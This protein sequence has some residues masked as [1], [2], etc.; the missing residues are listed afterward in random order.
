M[1]GFV[2][3]QVAYQPIIDVTAL[4]LDLMEDYEYEKKKSRQKPNGDVFQPLLVS[5]VDDLMGRYE[6]SVGAIL[7][8][9][10]E[11]SP[12]ELDGIAKYIHA[13]YPVVKVIWRSDNRGFSLWQHPENYDYV[14]FGKYMKRF[15][16]LELPTTNQRYYRIVDGI[17]H[18]ITPRFWKTV[19]S[20]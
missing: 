3:K 16:P 11:R 17:A 7:F 6:D 14:H 13:A 9:G 12:M 20:A 5:V 4:E 1:L 8:R 18:N 15:G 2:S 10:G 19:G